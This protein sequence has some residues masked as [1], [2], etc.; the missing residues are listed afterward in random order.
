M[1][2]PVTRPEF[3]PP[4]FEDVLAARERIANH[5][6]RTPVMTCATIDGMAGASLFFKCENLQKVG[7]FKARGAANAIFGLDEDEAA[8]GV[9]TH[10]S[11]NH[12]QA[13]AWAAG[14]RGIPATVVVPSSAPAPKKAAMRGYGA[15][16]VECEPTSAAREAT[17]ASLAEETGAT[18]VHPYND[19]RVIAGQGTCVLELLEQVPGLDA[20]IAPVGGGG[21]V[22]GCCITLRAQSPET[23]LY[24][25]EP[26]G[27][28]DAYRSLAAGRVLPQEDPRTIADGL[29]TGLGDLTW[30]FVSRDVEAVL[31]A[32]DAE[33][34]SAMRL[35]WERMKLVV[36]PSAAVPLAA[37]LSDPGRFEGKR[38]GLIFTGGNVDLERLPFTPG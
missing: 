35:V 38:V 3:N 8:R 10:S 9:L 19:A 15:R 36:E 6:H 5:V 4:G 21:L 11:G 37:L 17:A 16:I 1:T 26:T 18:F 34:V 27:A 7:A 28:D 29:R 31:L 22:S 2:S 33:I 32:T 14:R 24:A 20:V 30:H 12:G 23:L 13:L 25:A